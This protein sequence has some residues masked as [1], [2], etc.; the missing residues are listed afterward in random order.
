MTVRRINDSHA[1]GE[2]GLDPH[3]TPACAVRALKHLNNCMT[4][5]ILDTLA[6]AGRSFVVRSTCP[7]VDKR[8]ICAFR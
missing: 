3:P 1:M 2:R 6:A 5:I 4:G 8:T 7:G